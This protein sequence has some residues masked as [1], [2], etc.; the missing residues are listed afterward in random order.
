VTR[1]RQTVLLAEIARALESA[2]GADVRVRRALEH[3]RRLVAYDQ[4]VLTDGA[5]APVPRRFFVPE[6]GAPDRARLEAKSDALLRALE[7]GPALPVAGAAEVAHLALPLVA[8]DEVAG[9]L[10]LERAGTAFDEEDLL[11]LSVVASQL[12]AYLSALRREADEA[13]ARE[14]LAEAAR[15]RDRFLGVLSHELRNPLA[16][17]GHALHVLSRVEPGGAQARRAREVMERQ[18]AQLS[19]LV[20][21]LLDVTRVESGKV[22]LRRERLDLAG[23]VRRAAEDHR[24]VFTERGIEL[25][26]SC[27]PDALAVDGDAVRIEQV[28][29]NLLG[30]AAKFT[31]RGGRVEV[32]VAR[33]GAAAVVRVRDDGAGIPAELLPRLF[34]PFSQGDSTLDR[35]RGGL[36]LGL[37][38]ARGLVE[39]HGGSIAAAS[40]GAGR[41]AEFVVRLP[42]APGAAHPGEAAPSRAPPPR[43]RVLV[44]DDSPDAAETLRDVLEL[45]GHAVS[46]ARDGAEALRLVAELEPD[47][48][49]CDIGLP[50]MSGY[51]VARAVRGRASGRAPV[52]V[53]IT[54]YGR[55]EDRQRAAEAGFD[56]HL[57]KPVDLARLEALL[58]RR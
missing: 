45:S 40:E 17:I 47:V 13:A 51:D 9:V 33:D 11:I 32:T 31:D 29:G 53:A 50:G 2:A 15:R 34:E 43:R 16:P 3:L 12:G 4:A 19:R 30:N 18:F 21:D 14:Q 22:H 26:V 24:S 41:G 54:G 35:S 57:T 8:L 27:P 23:L 20:D 5:S 10:I 56:A 36:G 25:A 42:L 6:P 7:E 37:A 1:S 49:L 38:L 58:S 52:L 46:I 44:V 55:D 28:V 39:L 48:V